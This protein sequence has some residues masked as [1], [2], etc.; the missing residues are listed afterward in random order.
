[1]CAIGMCAIG[2][3]GQFTVCYRDVCYREVGY[4]DV[5]Y[6]DSERFT[7]CA[8]G[9]LRSLRCALSGSFAIYFVCY[10]DVRYRALRSIYCVLSGC[11][12]SHRVLTGRS[13]WSRPHTDFN[14]LDIYF[15][16]RFQCKTKSIIVLF[17]VGLPLSTQSEV[18]SHHLMLSVQNEV[19]NCTVPCEFAI[20][21]TKRHPPPPSAAFS[22]K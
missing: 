14:D 18:H 16:K 7:L 22:A 3:Y 9:M 12:L 1:M 11:V 8:I 10:R 4:R 2:H 6:R 13:Q 20:F 19:H 5:R 21:Y 15:G 17:H